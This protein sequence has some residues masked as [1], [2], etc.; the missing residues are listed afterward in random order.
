MLR[1]N[2]FTLIELLVVI[3]IIAILASM[4]LPA[5]SK[6]RGKAR[7]ISCINN[8]KQLGL[9]FALYSDDYEDYIVPY[10]MGTYASTYLT[11]LMNAGLLQ[12][13]D[14]EKLYPLQQ[15]CPSEARVRKNSS[16]TVYPHVQRQQVATYD[17]AIN[18]NLGTDNNTK[19]SSKMYK[20]GRIGNASR[21]IHLLEGKN[22]HCNTGDYV[23]FDYC[24]RRYTSRHLG[25]STQDGEDFS[26]PYA[27]QSNVTF[28]DGHVALEKPMPLR[29][30]SGGTWTVANGSKQWTP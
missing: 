15:E 17:Y 7:N 29:V 1:R 19:I 16:G 3:A 26:T 9:T 5:L 20:L 21:F 11:I 27:V 30:T 22:T 18:G 13:R 12:F 25:A 23:N 6:A 28:I 24:R 8:M 14:S 2:V 4:L 10:Q